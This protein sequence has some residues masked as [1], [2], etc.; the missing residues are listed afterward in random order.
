MKKYYSAAMM[1]LAAAIWGFA[2]SAQKIAGTLGAFTIGTVRN[3]FAAIF[4]LPV[5]AAIDKLSKSE[6]VLISKKNRRLIDFNKFELTGGVLCGIVLTVASALQQFGINDGTD[7]G[8]ASFITALYV[9]IVPIIGIFMGKRSPINVWVSVGIAVVGFYLLCIKG[10]FSMEASDISVLLCAL[11]F[12]GHII[13]IDRYAPSCD[14][15]R[16][17]CIQFASAMLLNLILTF[18]FESPISFGEIFGNLLPLIYLGIGSSGI[19]YTL[20]IA[21]QKHVHPAAGAVIL[22]LES[23]FGVIG[24]AILLKEVMTAREYIGCA[25]VFAAVI[26]SQ[27]DVISLI[28]SAAG[29]KSKCRKTTEKEEDIQ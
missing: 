16:M 15:V 4:L 22:S 5:I 19:A 6:R 18:I 1:L 3:L 8:K 17:S 20:Q 13:V 10:D 2:F 21:A 27:V 14:G 24:S 26:L 7:A 11:V 12:A 25:I 23:V 28:R 9:V 29:S